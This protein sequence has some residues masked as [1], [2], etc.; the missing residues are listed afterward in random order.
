MYF[1][2]FLPNPYTIQPDYLQNV[3]I[4]DWEK[5][6][7][8]NKTNDLKEESFE[9]TRLNVIFIVNGVN[10]M[11][12]SALNFQCIC[13]FTKNNA[14]TKTLF[15]MAM[16]ICNWL[17][18]PIV[19]QLY[20]HIF[21]ACKNEL[22]EPLDMIILVHRSKVTFTLS[23]TYYRWPFDKR[24][25]GIFIPLKD[26]STCCCM[27]N[28]LNVI[29]Q[30]P[31]S[32][33][34]YGK[35]YLF[36]LWHQNVKAFKIRTNGFTHGNQ[37]LLTAFCVFHEHQTTLTLIHSSKISCWI[38]GYVALHMLFI[39]YCGYSGVV[40]KIRLNFNPELKFS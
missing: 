34:D 22:F 1:V 30:L 23:N 21:S 3:Y 5:E 8:Y 7:V 18:N 4:I 38:H 15:T 6:E 2:N 13:A 27:N 12:S 11:G 32:F 35:L 10:K 40:V 36:G 14:F 37:A 26:C 24:S 28:M 9:S 29:L 31:V 19:L 25:L 33:L 20:K 16:N 39:I 17:S